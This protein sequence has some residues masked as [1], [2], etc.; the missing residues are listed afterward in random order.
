MSRNGKEHQGNKTSDDRLVAAYHKAIEKLLPLP[1]P[2][3]FRQVIRELSRE[4]SPAEVFEG[5]LIPEKLNELWREARILRDRYLS[6]LAESV[7]IREFIQPR[8]KN[9]K[10]AA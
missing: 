9:E 7:M 10:E 2:D 1:S 6:N 3:H 4:P 5:D 8:P